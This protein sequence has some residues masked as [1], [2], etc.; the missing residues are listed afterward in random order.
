VTDVLT[1]SAPYND[2]HQEL[3]E[4]EAIAGLELDAAGAVLPR[5][6]VYFDTRCGTYD[7]WL[8]NTVPKYLACHLMIVR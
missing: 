7:A 8:F 4:G 6:T 3:A 5:L 2:V 1:V